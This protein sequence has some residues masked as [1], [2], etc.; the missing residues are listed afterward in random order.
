MNRIHN[1]LLFTP[2]AAILLF[3]VSSSMVSAQIDY[4]VTAT[5]NLVSGPDPLGIDQ[6]TFTG[7]A[8]LIQTMTPT[9]SITTSTSSTNTYSGVGA[10]IQLGNLQCDNTSN[11]TVTLTDNA[12]APDTIGLSNCRIQDTIVSANVIVPAG[13]MITAVPAAIPL[14]NNI[15]GTISY[16]LG[17]SDDPSVFNL[18][19]AVILAVDSNPP[20]G[21]P[22]T[23][24]PS[25]TAWNPIASVGSTT[26]LTERITFATSYPAAA[27]SF[28]TSAATSDGGTWLSVTPAAINSSSSITISVNP[29]GLTQ[30]S[31]SGTVT[32][33]FGS[34]D[35]PPVL[36]PVSLTLSN[37]VVSGTSLTGPSSMTFG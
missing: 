9:S 36:I 7:T 4:S 2:V 17:S 33:S 8:T 15:S 13:A 32:L 3:L 23:I 18:T 5:L 31:Y 27:V 1:R 28:T 34:S 22:P 14:T 6:S 20:S 12:G 35:M 19:D 16:S 37:G 10:G 29:S 11:L 30:P 21:S 24:T 25:P 26:L